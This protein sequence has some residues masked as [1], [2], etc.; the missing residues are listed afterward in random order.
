MQ[1]QRVLVVCF[2]AVTS[3]FTATA[4]RA[5]GEL[6][7]IQGT[8]SDDAGKPIEGAIL[9]LSDPAKGRELSTKTDKNGKYYKRGIPGSEYQFSV[10]KEGYNALKDKMKVAAGGEHRYDFKLVKGAPEGAKEF[11]KGFDAFNK[12]NFEAAIVEFEAALAKAPDLVEIRVNLALAY[13]RAGKK[14]EAV[15][16]LEKAVT[17]AP[18][19]PRIMFQLGGAY[20]EMRDWDKA[21]GA[22]EK[23]LGQQPDLKD[24]LAYEATITLGAVY[25]AK[26]ETDKSIAYFEKALAAKPGTAVATLGL[27]KG[28]LSKGD[29]AKALQ[30]FEQVVAIAPG[31]SEATQAKTFID[32]LKKPSD[33][34]N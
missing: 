23:G 18:N 11:A 24:P 25:F 7:S 28:Y 16:Q 6:G 14:P 10:E 4:A 13:L 29:S 33:L 22:F 27:A 32:G 1:G 12:G 9:K 31:S 2:A 15:A 34:E 19:E 17:L 8:I 21:M 30:L 5:Q 20:V 26:G 3:L